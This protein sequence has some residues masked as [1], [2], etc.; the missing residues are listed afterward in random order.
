MSH[1]DSI[2]R[3]IELLSRLNEGQALNVDRL[4]AQYGVH[5]RSIRRDLALIKEIF[6]EFIRKDGD[7]YRAYDKLLLDRVLHSGEL[8]QLSGIASM[9]DL[10][11]TQTELTQETRKLLSES[12]RIYAYKNKPF[13]VL[14]H[15]EVVRQIEHVIKYRMVIDID[16][17]TQ[18]GSM[19]IPYEPYRIVF[20]QENFYLMG[21]NTRTAR[22]ELLRIGR[23]IGVQ[24]TGKTFLRDRDIERFIEQAQTPWANYDKP[25]QTVRIRVDTEVSKYFYAKNYLPSQKIIEQN[26]FG[27]IIV[28]YQITNFLEIEQLLTQWAGNID[29]LEPR[30]L[31][32]YIRKQLERKLERLKPKEKTQPRETTQAKNVHPSAQ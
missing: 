10:A 22:V 16:Y 3:T 13:E 6:G 9:F 12:E 14:H 4:A 31:K 29:I 30:S 5:P 18:D 23:I 20:M 11:S 1:S 2:R 21:K 15:P 27:Q 26:Q 17:Q 25:P 32:R 8:M 19:H 24:R 28:E 7:A